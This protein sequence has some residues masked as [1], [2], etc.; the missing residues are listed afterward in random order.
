MPLAIIYTKGVYCIK[1]ERVGY[2]VVRYFDI[3]DYESFDDGT[4][5]RFNKS[6]LLPVDMS[7]I[8]V[9]GSEA[10]LDHPLL[11]S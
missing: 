9:L 4:P 5:T 6:L 10:I 2:N 3:S 1:K 8:T 7:H 11:K